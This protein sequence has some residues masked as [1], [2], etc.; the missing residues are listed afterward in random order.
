[1][2][3]AEVLLPAFD[4]KLRVRHTN[5][6]GLRIRGCAQL[7]S[8]PRCSPQHGIDDWSLPF[9][10]KLHRLMDCCMFSG[11]EKEELI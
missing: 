2:F 5:K 7:A 3:Y 9:R 11:F 4:K 6:Q 8:S 10:A 1:M